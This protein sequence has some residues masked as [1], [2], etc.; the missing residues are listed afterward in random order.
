MSPSKKE[1]YFSIIFVFI[2]YY[3][4]IKKNFLNKRIKIYF[5]SSD[6]CIGCFPEGCSKL[7]LYLVLRQG[8]WLT[9]VTIPGAL[10]N[11]ILNFW[12]FCLDQ[13]GE[14]FILFSFSKLDGFVRSFYLLLT[15]VLR[16][17]TMIVN[18]CFPSLFF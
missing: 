3:V 15:D 10:E 4:L 6:I 14:S 9:S 2:S 11:H 1:K 18:L 17:S 5:R 8:I 13:L 7:I 16:S 12:I